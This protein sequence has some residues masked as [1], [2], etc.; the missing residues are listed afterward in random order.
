MDVPQNLHQR[1]Q[2]FKQEHVLLGWDKLDQAAQREFTHQLERVNFEEL[3]AL[4]ASRDDSVGIDKS[5]IAPL[6][7]IPEN[8]ISNASRKLGRE[9]IERGELAVLLVAGGQGSRLGFEKPKGL[10]PIGPVSNKTLFEIHADK[11]F[12][13]SKRAKK[14]VPFLIMTSA[15]THDETEAYFREKNYFGLEDVFFFQQGTMPAVDLVTGRLLLEKPGS[16]FT[17][18]NGHGGTLTALAETGLLDQL[19]QRGIKYIHYFQVDNPLVRIGDAAFLGQ[20]IADRSEASS[21]SIA[22][23]YPEEKMGVFA[24]IN[25]RCGIIE[26][27]DLPAEFVT[28]TD[29]E[30]KLIYRAGSPA[31]HLFDVKF[32]KRITQGP[33]RLPFH[34]AKKKVACIDEQGNQVTPEKENALK[35]ELFV[36]DALPMAERWLVVEANRHEEFA[37][38]KNATGLD[39]PAT[40]QQALS[41]LA[42]LWLEQSGVQVPR[43]Q[44][45]HV[46]VPLEI[47]P[48][49]AL[50]PE[51]LAEKIK[52]GHTIEGSTYLE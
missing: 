40:C 14:P 48:R 49:F 47:S 50:D 5:Q 10:F 19:D 11:V 1:L 20:H 35:F 52:E 46:E 4:Y 38:V 31:I 18:P 42:G 13:L 28:A 36:F 21:K 34:V 2:R 12:A 39:S 30:G 3:A 27:S 25:G 45:G 15:A 6:S 8:E 7:T 37:P 29:E 24:K 43:N 44:E 9:A 33:Q 16:L 51:E 17:S 41:N 32:L 22:K 26:Y 23:A